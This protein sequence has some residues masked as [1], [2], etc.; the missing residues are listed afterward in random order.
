VTLAI[1]FGV[2]S[3]DHHQRNQLAENNRKADARLALNQYNNCRDLESVKA[4]ANERIELLKVAQKAVIFKT[5]EIEREL[6]SLVERVKPLAKVD[7]TPLRPG[8]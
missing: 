6:A 8:K 1:A 2:G 5:P 4:Q 3:W 7:C